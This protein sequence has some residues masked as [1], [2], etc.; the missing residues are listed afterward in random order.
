[1]PKKMPK[2]KTPKKVRGE[3]AHEKKEREMEFGRFVLEDSFAEGRVPMLI[4]FSHYGHDTDYSLDCDC[5]HMSMSF[6]DDD[7]CECRDTI[8]Y[9]GSIVYVCAEN[10]TIRTSPDLTTYYVEGFDGTCSR[11]QNPDIYEAFNNRSRGLAISRDVLMSGNPG[12]DVSF[13]ISSPGINTY[14]VHPH[15]RLI[16]TYVGRVQKEVCISPKH[17]K[18]MAPIQSYALHFLDIATAALA[19]P[20]EM[21]VENAHVGKR[22]KR[23][24]Q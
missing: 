14:D 5:D 19:V 8:V 15:R 17:M 11:V 23:K 20:K 6:Y 22:K 13:G 16:E 21:I 9:R 4:V 7:W 10:N 12:D 18:G 1:M 2:K 24:G 3:K